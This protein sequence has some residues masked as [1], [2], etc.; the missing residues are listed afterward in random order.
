MKEMEIRRTA[1]QFIKLHGEHAWLEAS[2]RAD[3]AVEDGD[4]AAVRAWK[5]VV[6]AIDELQRMQPSGAIN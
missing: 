3:K 5:R 6:A 2:L 4:E 1:A